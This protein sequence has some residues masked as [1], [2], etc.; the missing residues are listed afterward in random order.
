MGFRKVRFRVV[1]EY[2]TKR[3]NESIS[4]TL[5]HY[6][7]LLG[8]KGSHR[9]YLSVA[10]AR[11]NDGATVAGRQRCAGASLD[12]DAETRQYGS[13]Q[14]HFAFPCPP[15]SLS[16]WAGASTAH[17]RATKMRAETV[18]LC[19]AG[20]CL[21]LEPSRKISAGRS[22][23][24]VASATPVAI[25]PCTQGSQA[26]PLSLRLVTLTGLVGGGTARRE[27]CSSTHPRTYHLREFLVD[28]QQ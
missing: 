2:I 13:I 7:V 14:A 17:P 20:C 3:A 25:G 12:R 27:K 8:F 4:Y 22:P 15:L 26:G 23:S 19:L 9:R 1:V 16:R 6:S 5:V 28:S 21:S 18:A 10:R 24:H 11:R